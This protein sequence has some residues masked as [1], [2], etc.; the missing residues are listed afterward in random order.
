MVYRCFTAKKTDYAVEAAAAL[1]DIRGN[2]R[3]EA[4][5]GLTI[6]NRYDVEGVSPEL[7]ARAKVTVFSEPPLS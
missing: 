1:R 2:L 3:I 5:E 4:A 7:Y 6:Y